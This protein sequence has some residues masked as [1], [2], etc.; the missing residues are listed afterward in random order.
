VAAVTRLTNA[1]KETDDSS[2]PQE[3]L[4]S[5]KSKAKSSHI[6]TSACIK[7]HCRIYHCIEI[8]L[9]KERRAGPCE[10]LKRG[11]QSC[12]RQQIGGSAKSLDMFV[13]DFTKKN[14]LLLFCR[15]FRHVPQPAYTT[16]Y[17][18]KDS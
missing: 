4:N 9:Q 13:V 3:R 12:V 10:Q 1:D 16:L 14:V 2:G 15:A 5:A 11:G 8:A 7:H 18:L 6:T 17:C